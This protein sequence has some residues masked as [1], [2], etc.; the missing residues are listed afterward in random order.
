MHLK[1]INANTWSRLYR[2]ICTSSIKQWDQDCAWNIFILFS[3]VPRDEWV[4]ESF[5]VKVA[6][7]NALLKNPFYIEWPK[8]I[9]E[10]G[11]LSKEV[12]DNTCAELTRAM[13]ETLTHHSNG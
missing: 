12:I 4:L 10:L 2:V 5:D 1:R 13:Y 3:Y 7:L 8:G 11:F 6:V 9:K